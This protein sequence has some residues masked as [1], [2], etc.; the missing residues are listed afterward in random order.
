M[1]DTERGAIRAI[2]LA[3]GQGTRM[4]SD[5]PK[6]LHEVQGQAMVNRVV[7]AARLAGAEG[8]VVVVG[9]GR[10][11]VREA[12]Q[13]ASGSGVQI[14]FSVQEQ[15][16]GTADAVRCALPAL[17]GFDGV[18]LILY[19]DVPNIGA[20]TL[21]ELIAL[22]EGGGL[23]L[24]TTHVED[25]TGYGRI[26]RGSEDERGGEVV[27]IV[28]HKD[29]S[30]AQR[31]ITEVNAGLYAVPVSMLREHVQDIAAE[32]EARELYL[33]DLIAIAAQ[34]RGARALVLDDPQEAMGVN[35]QDQ[36]TAANAWADGRQG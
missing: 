7:E 4:Q 34:G 25:P 11:A 3:A 10:D 26:I 12:V 6:V 29:A 5:R 15:Q 28:E 32:N 24:I 16:L 14:D 30:P 35:D 19:G 27:A 31:R 2:V 36:L 13:G 1:T 22:A 18:V 17:E 21:K 20:S 9:Y 8:A 33:T 23:A